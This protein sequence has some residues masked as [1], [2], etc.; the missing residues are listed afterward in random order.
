MT[1]LIVEVSCLGCSIWLL[2]ERWRISGLQGLHHDFLKISGIRNSV[3]RESS[4]IGLWEVRIMAQKWLPM[5]GGCEWC[6]DAISSRG[7][8]FMR[9][10]KATGCTPPWIFSGTCH[11]L[12]DHM[13]AVTPEVTGAQPTGQSTIITSDLGQGIPPKVEYAIQRN[14]AY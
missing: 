8:K 12:F 9:S 2:D 7:G 11:P 6:C 13:H 10:K 1:W 14:L 3:K 4:Y 5:W